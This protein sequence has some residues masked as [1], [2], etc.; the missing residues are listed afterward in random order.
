MPVIGCTPSLASLSENSRAP[1]RLFDIGYRERRHSIRDR[2][3]GELGDVHRLLRAAN[4]SCEH[5]DARSPHRPG[6][7]G[8]F[9]LP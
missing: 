8:V 7:R 5:E 1:K 6:N 3:L 2:K 9:V 4:R